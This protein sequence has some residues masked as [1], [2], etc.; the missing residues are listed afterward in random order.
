MSFIKTLKNGIFILSTFLFLGTSLSLSSHAFVNGTYVNGSTPADLFVSFN[1][2]IITSNVTPNIATLR[3][4]NITSNTVLITPGLTNISVTYS[5]TNTG[6]LGATFNASLRF[7]NATFNATA[8]DAVNYTFTAS[9]NIF[10]SSGSTATFN[11]LVNAGLGIVP[12]QPVYVDARVVESGGAGAY[13]D[14]FYGSSTTNAA[15]QPP[16]VWDASGSPN[17]V[18]ITVTRNPASAGIVTV[19]ITF[20]DPMNTAIAPSVN[21]LTVGGGAAVWPFTGSFTSSTVW[22]GTFNVP[23]AMS[24]IY[25]GTATISVSLGTDLTG[26]VMLPTTNAATFVIDTRVPTINLVHLGTTPAGQNYLFNLISSEALL[27]TPSMVASFNTG[28]TTTLVTVS[29]TSNTA[30]I[31]WNGFVAVPV[32]ANLNS[33]GTFN[34]LL[35]SDLAGNT[36]NVIFS[37]PTFNVT[38]PI[39]FFTGIL[40]DNYFVQNGDTVAVQPVIQA[41]Y[42]NL[43]GGTPI[44]SSIRVTIDGILR[45]TT[46]NS[47]T[48]VSPNGYYLSFVVTPGIAFTNG[49]H[50]IDIGVIDALLTVGTP[51]TRSVQV[52]G[53][54]LAISKAPANVPNP[55][56]PNNDGVNDTTDIIYDLTA[57][58]EI[59]LRIYTLTGQ[60]VYRQDIPS[61]SQG[62]HAGYNTV[63]WDGRSTFYSNGRERLPNGTYICQVIGTINGKKQSLGKL[64]IVILN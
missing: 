46:P 54:T 41:A 23:A 34:T 58:G 61:G 40:F 3:A 36:T 56:S 13:K 2:F 50:L 38:S 53:T 11:F 24:A 25:D 64:K 6:S 20:N 60:M 45:F 35:V 57:D 51:I 49:T 28:V 37:G 5:V 55:F 62:A 42:V 31:T 29:F 14:D 32:S 18:S 17:I 39:P 8:L 43:S 48:Q 15:A 22:V 16:L 1:T 30:G 26:L 12:T 9:N 10:L 44:L 7:F 19:S 27:T 47:I 21:F 52:G 59:S 4:Q 63:T 33:V